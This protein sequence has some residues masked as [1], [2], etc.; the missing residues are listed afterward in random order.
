[1]AIMSRRL[2]ALIGPC[3]LLLGP[4]S[5]ASA[6]DVG[7]IP[8]PLVEVSAGYAYMRDTSIEENFPKGWY[9]SG[10]ANLTN[11]FGVAGEV[12]GA[13]KTFADLQDIPDVVD[14]SVKTNIYTFMAGPRFFAKQGRFVPFAQVLAGAAH[15]RVKTSVPVMGISERESETKFAFQTGGGFTILLSEN[16]GIRTAVDYRRI[17]IGEDEGGEDDSEVRGIAGIVFGWGTR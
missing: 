1:M 17:V 10:A 16:V 14:F 5:S 15:L 4:V 11:W 9:F 6:Q 2:L 3:V 12:T 7:A 8:V 13:H